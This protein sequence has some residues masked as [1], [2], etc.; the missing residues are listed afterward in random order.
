MYKTIS[1]FILS[2]S[3][4]SCNNDEVLPQANCIE[5]EV[6]GKIR[7]AGGGIA[8]SLA[9]P[10]SGSVSWQ[11]HENVIELLNVPIEFTF[12]G[13]PLYFKA[14]EAKEGERGPISSDG[15]ES[16]QLVLF[17]TEISN[18]GCPGT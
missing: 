16:I 12:A 14:R 11:E 6:V 9:E 4:L 2:A 17:G 7:S 5:G 15:D 1:I 13:T 3:L 8:V 10:M 18:V